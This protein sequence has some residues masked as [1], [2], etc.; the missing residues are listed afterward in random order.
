M[1]DNHLTENYGGDQRAAIDPKGG[2][3]M[4]RQAFC[5]L[6]AVATYPLRSLPF[7]LLFSKDQP[8]K[9]CFQ[10]LHNPLRFCARALISPEC[11]MSS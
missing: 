1:Y 9:K 10:G 3:L 11:S 2:Y 8:D 7:T 4:Q 5:L 6:N